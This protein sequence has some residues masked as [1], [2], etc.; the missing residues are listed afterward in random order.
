M[1]FEK[2]ENWNGNQNGRPKGSE[3]K[4]KA[5]LKNIIHQL[6][7]K[8]SSHLEEWID[9]TAKTDP[10]KAIELYTKLSEFVLPKIRHIHNQVEEINEPRIGSV[11]IH[12]DYHSQDEQPL[13][14]LK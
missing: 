10:A 4:V 14:K 2:G 12:H 9:R 1:P 13:T 5:D 11:K 6:L 3:N 7:E 8:K